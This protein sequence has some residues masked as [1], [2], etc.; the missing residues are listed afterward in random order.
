M[1]L[2]RIRS[3]SIMLAVL[4]IAALA[5]AQTPVFQP[6]IPGQRFARAVAVDGRIYAGLDRGGVAEF[7]VATTTMLRHLDRNQGLGGHLV[8]D[9]AWSGSRL[10]V[11]TQ[12]GGITAISNPGSAGEF[13]QLYSTGLASLDVTC[14][15]GQQI[16]NSERIYYGTD[17]NGIGVIEGGREGSYYSTPQLINDTVEH[18]AL[19]GPLLLI[20]TPTGVSR[21]ANNTFTNY[22]SEDTGWPEIRDLTVAPDGEIW[23]ATSD[24]LYTWDDTARELV[25]AYGTTGYQWL[26]FDGDAVLALANNWSLLRLTGGGATLTVPEVDESTDLDIRMAVAVDGVVWVGGSVRS[27]ADAAQSVASAAWLAVTGDPAAELHLLDACQLGFDGGYHG[28]AVDQHGRAWV[29]DRKADGIAGLDD[30]WYHI[31]SVATPENGEVGL[32]DHSGDILSMSRAGEWIW[33]N[34]YT[35]GI[36]GF[37]P[38]A[39]PGG[40]E[41]WLQLNKYTSPLQ[42]DGIIALGGHPDGA[43][44]VCSDVGNFWGGHA[45]NDALAV[46]VLFDLDNPLE[47]SS[48]LHLPVG[49]LGGNYILTAAVERR[50]VVWFSVQGVG[51]MRWD[52]NGP[53]SGP[54]D[55]LTWSQTG[56]DQWLG[57]IRFIEGGTMDL[58]T[59]VALAFAPDGSIWAGGA[60]LTRFTYSSSEEMVDFLGEWQRKD[61]AYEPG[62]LNGSVKGLAFDRNDDLWALN[63]AGLNRFRIDGQDVEVDAFTDL[64]SYTS[65]DWSLYSPGAISPLPGGSY[66]DLDVSADGARLVLTSDLG[67]VMLD[68]PE[69]AAAGDTDIDLAFIYPNPFPGDD[70]AG[71]INIGGLAVDEDAPVRLEIL[72]LSGQ[73]VFQNNQVTDPEDLWDGRNR[74]GERVASGMYV[75]KISQA[76]VVRTLPLAVTF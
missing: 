20:S 12:D 55:P 15:T 21:F 31:L 1:S 11:A 72:N 48:W 18:V 67:A 17:G 66:R 5:A 70:G 74:L 23:A 3:C 75:M 62:L 58:G 63:L 54:D 46:D 36:V 27:E 13:V 50:D 61:N 22:L 42:P 30:E 60:G 65:L 32:L 38:P 34:Q 4:L 57:P 6:I 33:F 45:P 9:L 16:G 8:Q 73:I 64:V 10:L 25:H 41:R 28:A 53:A 43:V 26:G 37:A 2:N 39:E 51:L 69:R 56:D 24:G 71:H 47:E 35:N 49:T 14:V 40:E 52:I 19:S 76:G 29:G 59:T 68:V 44:I 7:D